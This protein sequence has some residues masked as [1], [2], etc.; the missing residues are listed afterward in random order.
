MTPWRAGGVDADPVPWGGIQRAA[1]T[2]MLSLAVVAMSTGCASDGNPRRPAP[3]QSVPVSVKAEA[4]LVLRTGSFVAQEQVLQR[5]EAVLRQKCMR[6]A[7]FNY[8]LDPAMDSIGADPYTFDPRSAASLGYGLF[9][10]AHQPRR[11]PAND[12]YV[13]T[14]PPGQQARYTA[15]LF[16]TRDGAI[17]TP[18]GLTTNFPANGCVA[19]ARA[20]LYT[21]VTAWAQVTHIP[22]AVKRLIVNRLPVSEQYRRAQRVWIG[23]MRVFHVNATSFTSPVA[24]VQANYNRVG[25]TAV[26][27]R[28]ELQMAAMDG[29]CRLK[30]HTDEVLRDI[31]V[32]LLTQEPAQTRSAL[33]E[34][35]AARGRALI[36]AY[37]VLRAAPH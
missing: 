22:Q 19:S 8:V 15:A 18:D 26:A 3:P 5:A 20:R 6:Q 10:A 23:C 12:V 4:D 7:G 21:N 9:S 34:L 14:L 1:W 37:A 31:S 17:T 27:R 13:R 25:Y 24:A 16:G 11:L 30:L 36:R 2:L 28:Y 29:S 35:A 33:A 32:T